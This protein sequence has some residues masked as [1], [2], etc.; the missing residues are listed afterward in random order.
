MPA[1]TLSTNYEQKADG[2]YHQDRV[3][4]RA[5]Q[6][7]LRACRAAAG[8]ARGRRELHPVLFRDGRGRCR[9]PVA[10]PG[11]HVVVAKVLYWGAQAA[12]RV[13]P[14][15]GLDVEFVDT[16]DLAWRWKRAIRPGATR[17]V[18]LETPANPTWEIT[19]LAA[20][21]RLAHDRRRARSPWTTRSGDAGARRWPLAVRRRS[22]SC[23][24]PPST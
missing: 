8:D 10:R 2:P 4:A 5:G 18:W 7:D 9:L 23:T 22:R 6:S 20:V 24:P 3:Y 1:V 11:D 14:D 21:C 15:M 17:L 19:D 12:R 16:T 13:R